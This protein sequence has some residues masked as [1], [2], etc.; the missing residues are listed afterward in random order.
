MLSDASRSSK[1][2]IAKRNRGAELPKLV[3]PVDFEGVWKGALYLVSQE[4][5][6]EKFNGS[7]VVGDGPALAKGVL[8]LI[9]LENRARLVMVE[10]F[11]AELLSSAASTAF[12]A[13]LSVGVLAKTL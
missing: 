13:K 4:R 11:S 12:V 10:R 7:L 6:E 1:F 5:G 2:R 9:S 3:R 8:R